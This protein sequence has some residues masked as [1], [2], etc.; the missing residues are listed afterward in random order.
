TSPMAFSPDGRT[1]AV[2]GQSWDPASLVLLDSST[3]TKL[4][5]QPRHLPRWRAKSPDVAFSA[6]GRFLAASFMLMSPRNRSSDGV[7][8]RTR[9]LVWDLSHLKRRPSVVPTP[10]TGNLERMALSPHGSRVYLSSPVAAYSTHTG[11]RLWRLPGK[12]VFRPID[13]SDDG[14]RLAV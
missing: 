13:L 11:K 12:G 2:A 5:D 10:V 9:T 8:D 1:L 6:D 3:L 14:S 7:P 4:P